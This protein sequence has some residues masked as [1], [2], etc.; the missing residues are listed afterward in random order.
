MHKIAISPSPVTIC[1]W[2]VG[3]NALCVSTERVCVCVCVWDGVGVVRITV[4]ITEHNPA[5]KMGR[6][7]LLLIFET[8]PWGT[9]R[10]RG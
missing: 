2:N 4:H 6:G 3:Q 9:Q 5:E 1:G 8:S 7:G 10:V